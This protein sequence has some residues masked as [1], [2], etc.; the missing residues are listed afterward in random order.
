M[1]NTT[2]VVAN[3][4]DLAENRLPELLPDDQFECATL[5]LTFVKEWLASPFT[6]SSTDAR[7]L[8]QLFTAIERGEQDGVAAPENTVVHDQTISDVFT[9]TRFGKIDNNLNSQRHYL[10][11]A[12][13]KS[14]AG[15]WNGYTIFKIITRLQLITDAKTPQNTHKG[16]VFVHECLADLHQNIALSQ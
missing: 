9:G 4:S 11:K 2:P 1:P 16:M 15:W 10:A 8:Y 3:V 13:L 5:A 7:M 12:S 6:V 14:L